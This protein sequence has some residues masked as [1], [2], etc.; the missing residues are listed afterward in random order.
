MKRS[1]TI[2]VLI[3]GLLVAIVDELVG[4][5]FFWVFVIVGL[6]LAAVAARTLW[7]KH[8]S[9]A[10]TFLVAGTLWQL[11]GARQLAL[12]ALVVGL[13]VELAVRV[14]HRLAHT[15]VSQYVPRRSPLVRVMQLSHEELV[16]FDEVKVG[17]RVS[18][19]AGERIP[20]DGRLVSDHAKVRGLFESQAEL[21]SK[22]DIVTSGDIALEQLIIE[23]TST[24]RESTW[25]QLSVLIT[26][27]WRQPMPLIERF[28]KLALLAQVAMI[29]GTIV[30]YF[31]D[32]HSGGPQ[33]A[34][35][36]ASFWLGPLL[37]RVVA[38]VTL[39]GL[40]RA[41]VVLKD[42][43]LLPRLGKLSHV[44]LGKT[45]IVTVGLPE[46]VAVRTG[47]GL[48]ENDVIRAA[49]ALESQID[50]PIARAVMRRATTLG[51]PLP[52][53][54]DA[55]QVQ[56]LGV[57]GKISDETFLLGREQLLA[58]ANLTLPEELK[59]SAEHYS[60]QGATVI[61]LATTERVLALFALSD[62]VRPS[63]PFLVSALQKNHIAVDLI[64]G[65]AK[66]AVEI[67]GATI[68]LTAKNIQVGL[69]PEQ[70]TDYLKK[71][72]PAISALVADPAA[73]ADAL[74][75]A[76][77]GVGWH[78]QGPALAKTSTQLLLRSN[79]LLS[80]EQARRKL[81]QLNLF[82]SL[83]P[84]ISLLPLAFFATQQILRVF[85]H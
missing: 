55:R 4:N 20:V 27:T 51:L 63:A 80:F 40:L 30:W 49:A 75:A 62:I 3:L 73:D 50:H 44:V 74:A 15:R 16:A 2:P 72:R 1:W 12:L 59:K 81:N 41:G 52:T 70:K 13:L 65:D 61:F 17:H 32:R 8:S 31:F 78:N 69:T 48:S 36:A 58:S 25:S 34:V 24:A 77:I 83:V 37:A 60:E 68:G 22:G 6:C 82:Q 33:L 53:A 14:V 10:L 28:Q 26:K 43:G 57:A 56:G 11:S 29:F 23:A 66:R 45:G 84:W 5:R 18:V 64:S 76:Q 21:L 42:W 38:G 9:P 79:D 67:I 47:S 71:L 46:L 39:A 35:L 54:I 85:L 7:K 19:K